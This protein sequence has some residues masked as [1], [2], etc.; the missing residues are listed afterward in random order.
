MKS[1][2][3]GS[4][5]IFFFRLEATSYS[6]VLNITNYIEKNHLNLKNHFRNMRFVLHNVCSNSKLMIAPVNLLKIHFIPDIQIIIRIR[7]GR[8]LII[9]SKI[10]SHIILFH[11]EQRSLCTPEQ[12]R[13]NKPWT[14]RDR[15]TRVSP[16]PNPANFFLSQFKSAYHSCACTSINLSFSNTT[17]IQSSRKR[18]RQ[19]KFVSK[20]HRPLN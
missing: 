13:T 16:L 12:T 7:G 3:Y 10:H 14:R 4:S 2:R 9:L 20:I 11:S 6:S 19:L 1:K 17:N 15:T 8:A 5:V 18:G